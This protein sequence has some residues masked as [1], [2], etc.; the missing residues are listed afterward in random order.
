M[1]QQQ[2]Y[3]GLMGFDA[4]TWQ[5]TV[6]EALR[7]IDPRALFNVSL[8]EMD[9]RDAGQE[10]PAD[11]PGDELAAHVNAWLDDLD[12]DGDVATTEWQGGGV[13]LVVRARG[14]GSAWRGWVGVPS[15]NMLEPEIPDLHLTTGA[16][17]R[18]IDLSL[19][20]VEQL[21]RGDLR[22]VGQGTS[23]QDTFQGL[24]RDMRHFEAKQVADMPMPAIQA[25]AGLLG[26]VSAPPEL[27]NYDTTWRGLHGKP[28]D[29]ANEITRVHNATGRIVLT[30]THRGRDAE[31][32]GGITAMRWRDEGA[33]TGQDSH[34]RLALHVE[35]G[36]ELFVE[37]SGELLPVEVEPEDRFLRTRSVEDESSDPILQLPTY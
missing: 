24:A 3:A 11:F 14:R 36:G 29:M 15:F 18:L 9:F 1:Q 32:L 13:S 4:D 26:M 34:V 8:K 12:P 21:A 16:R 2:D 31:G 7:P 25:Y 6:F 28:P 23:Y 33:Q 30:A 37:L 5:R 35:R 10:D 22:V 20:E 19:D 17:R 27:G